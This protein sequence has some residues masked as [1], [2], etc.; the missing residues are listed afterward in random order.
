MVYGLLNPPVDRSKIKENRSHSHFFQCAALDVSNNT[1]KAAMLLLLQALKVHDAFTLDFW[2]I[3]GSKK[4]KYLNKRENTLGTDT[5]FELLQLRRLR[6]EEKSTA[7]GSSEGAPH[8]K[9]LVTR[10]LVLFDAKERTFPDYK[11][12]SRN[13]LCGSMIQRASSGKAKLRSHTIFML[14]SCVF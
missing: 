12:I 2:S 11:T 5:R 10:T 3:W 6:I 8:V 4:F 7:R 1:L 13:N 14:L 9:N